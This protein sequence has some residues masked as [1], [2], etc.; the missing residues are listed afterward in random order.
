LRKRTGGIP[1]LVQFEDFG[2][3]L[4]AEALAVDAMGVT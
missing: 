3:K 1:S 4:K 2:A